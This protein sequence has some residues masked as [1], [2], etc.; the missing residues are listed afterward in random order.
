MPQEIS[1]CF[2]FLPI[3]THV[4]LKKLGDWKFS[5]H[6]QM[7]T[8]TQLN[9]ASSLFSNDKGKETDGLTL[10]AAC[11]WSNKAPASDRHWGCHR[12]SRTGTPPWTASRHL[13]ADEPI[14]KIKNKIKVIHHLNSNIFQCLVQR[15]PLCLHSLDRKFSISINLSLGSSTFFFLKQVV[16]QTMMW[17]WSIL[18]HCRSLS[19][20]LNDSD[21]WYVKLLK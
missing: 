17:W 14:K 19:I 13:K 11:R 6:K 5:L 8:Y 10:S 7:F 9:T 20:N 12:W 4:A 3:H 15:E 18:N 2:S 16:Q 1:S 21:F